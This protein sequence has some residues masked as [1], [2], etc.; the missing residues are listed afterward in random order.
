MFFNIILSVSVALSVL[1]PDTSINA[2]ELIY[3]Y[4]NRFIT[5]ANPSDSIIAPKDVQ[6]IISGTYSS[7]NAYEK[8]FTLDPNNGED[9]NLWIKN[10]STDT[11][12]ARITMGSN[13]PLEVSIDKD[14]QKTIKMGATKTT[15]VKVYVYS[16]TG[17]KMDITISA[18]QF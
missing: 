13:S 16:K 15:D 4:T 10:T 18:R 8:S 14:S 2:G 12:Y 7:Y 5:V 11:L 1:A 17:H 3:S 9:A 6:L